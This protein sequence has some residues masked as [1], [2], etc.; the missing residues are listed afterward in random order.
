M[1]N[2]IDVTARSVDVNF[3]PDGKVVILV[4]TADGGTLRLSLAPGTAEELNAL[5][6]RG[7]SA[8]RQNPAAP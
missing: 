6:M 4:G 3:L 7:L 8:L 5:L 2:T 1:V